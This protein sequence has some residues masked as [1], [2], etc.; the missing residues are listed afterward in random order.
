MNSS[1]LIEDDVFDKFEKLSINDKRNKFNEEMIKIYELIVAV[2]KTQGYTEELS[3]INN[4]NP[5][6]HNKLTEDEYLLMIYKDLINIRKV[7]VNY[8]GWKI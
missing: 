5:T 2:T 6:E 4:Y 3:K 1:K 7:L 8:I